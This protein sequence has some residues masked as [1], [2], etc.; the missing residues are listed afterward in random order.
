MRRKRRVATPAEQASASASASSTAGQKLVLGTVQPG[1]KLALPYGFN[2][3]GKQLL[4]RLLH[5]RNAAFW[6]TL[7]SCHYA[8]TPP[9]HKL[10]RA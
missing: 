8:K 2:A 7:S 4:V 9:C 3:P 5:L 6:E 1:K 10:I